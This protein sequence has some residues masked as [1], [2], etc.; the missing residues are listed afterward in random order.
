MDVCGEK[1]S[2]AEGFTSEVGMEGR[3][4]EIYRSPRKLGRGRGGSWEGGVGRGREGPAGELA[5]L[6]RVLR[7]SRSGGAARGGP[8]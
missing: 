8:A 3:S 1:G 5:C 7:N 6:Q 4:Q 2:E